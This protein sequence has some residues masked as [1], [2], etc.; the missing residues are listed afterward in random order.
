MDG[1]CLIALPIY[2]TIR[3]EGRLYRKS[4]KYGDLTSNYYFVMLGSNRA[5]EVAEYPDTAP[6]AA[7]HDGVTFLEFTSLRIRS[8]ASAA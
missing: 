1:Y 7:Q 4:F 3:D 5:D 2:D 6:A 8:V